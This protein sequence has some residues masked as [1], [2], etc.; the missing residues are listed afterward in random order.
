MKELITSIT[1]HKQA[2]CLRQR[3][4][5]GVVEVRSSPDTDAMNQIYCV[6]IEN[7]CVRRH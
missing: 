4:E 6:C 1:V 7:L 3:K 5:A 2:L